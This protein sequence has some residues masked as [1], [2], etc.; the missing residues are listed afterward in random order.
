MPS[1]GTATR[2][3][4]AISPGMVQKH[5][6]PFGI[7]VN[8]RG[9]RFVDEGADLRNYTYAKYGHEILKQQQFAWQV[10]DGKVLHLLRD[11][12]GSAR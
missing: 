7:M 5:S 4:S 10:F 12:Y 9:E 11:E 2:P 3:S 6:Y 8:A 1:A